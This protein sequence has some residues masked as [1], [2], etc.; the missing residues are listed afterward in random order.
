MRRG[1]VAKILQAR[2]DD[3][4]V[5]RNMRMFPEKDETLYS[6]RPTDVS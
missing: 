2:N 5:L 3:T 1:R 4:E 6:E